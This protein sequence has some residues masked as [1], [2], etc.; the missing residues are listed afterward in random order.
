MFLFKCGLGSGART[1]SRSRKRSFRRPVP[2]LSLGT[3]E[4]S[5]VRVG[6]WWWMSSS[7][8]FFLADT[9]NDETIQ[10]QDRNGR[11]ARRSQASHMD[12]VPS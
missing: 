12:A 5:G 1:T 11:A 7:F 3:S 9:E 10:I 2:K 4:R 8:D 6:C